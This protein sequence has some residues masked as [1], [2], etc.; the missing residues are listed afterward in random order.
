MRSLAVWQLHVEWLLAGTSN[1]DI[2]PIRRL[3]TLGLDSL[4]GGAQ[5]VNP[6]VTGSSPTLVN[7]PLFN[8]K[9]FQMYPISFPCGLLLS[10]P[11]IMP[12]NC[13]T[14][15]ATQAYAQNRV[16]TVATLFELHS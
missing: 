9:V 11:C 5:H 1:E 3:P 6:E 12:G 2:D 7:F 13:S 14:D 4:V 10:C 16:Q 15:S 8:P